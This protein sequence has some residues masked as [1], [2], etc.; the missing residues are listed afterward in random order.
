MK[1]DR[2]R[3]SRA[4]RQREINFFNVMLPVHPLMTEIYTCEEDCN[5]PWKHGRKV[6]G[7]GLFCECVLRTLNPSD[8]GSL[9]FLQYIA[10]AMTMSQNLCL[11]VSVSGIICVCVWSLLSL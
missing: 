6:K 7:T 3:G 5:F 8:L 10:L 1:G 4:G 2:C 9:S 11:C